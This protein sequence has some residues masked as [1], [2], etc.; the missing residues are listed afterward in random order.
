MGNSLISKKLIFE[1]EQD[2]SLSNHNSNLYAKDIFTNFFYLAIIAF[3]ILLFLDLF[4]YSFDK[5]KENEIERKQCLKEY[6]EHECHKVTI[7]D[8]PILNNFCKQ[9]EKCFSI[10]HERVYFHS[11]IVK[12]IRE[13]VNGLLFEFSYKN[14]VTYICVIISLP[15]V[16]K[17]IY[18]L[19]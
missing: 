15:L 2:E 9:K 10:D 12:F 13:I 6:E 3:I 4:F 14:L 1:D 18:S 8:G 5:E 17:V 7:D 16:A 19:L 11:I